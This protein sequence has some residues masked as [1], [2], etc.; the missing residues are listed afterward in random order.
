MQGSDVKSCYMLTTL[1]LGH[2]HLK[3]LST[4]SINGLSLLKTLDI[5][6]IKTG[7]NFSL[8]ADIFNTLTNLTRVFVVTFEMCCLTENHVQCTSDVKSRDRF[9]SCSDVMHNEFLHVLTYLYAATS[10]M[11]NAVSL[12]WH[13]HGQ[14]AVVIRLLNV[15]LDF[16][17]ALISVY[18]FMILGA[19]YFYRGNIEYV[20]MHWKKSLLCRAAG[21]FM[22]VSTSMSNIAT[23]LISVD[24]CICIVFQPFKKR[25]FTL[26]Q[27]LICLAAVYSLSVLPLSLMSMQSTKAI[28]NSVCLMVGSSMQWLF[29]VT[30][31]CC[32]FLVFTFTS[33]ECIAVIITIINSHKITTKSRDK[34]TRVILRLSAVVLTNF[35]PS[36]AITFL[37]IASLAA[38][39]IPAS[40]E[41]NI[42]YFL[43]PINSCLNPVINT[44][45]TQEFLQHATVNAIASK[46]NS[47]VVTF[48]HKGINHFTEFN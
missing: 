4:Q 37:S 10:I 29:S 13:L 36:M 47:F 17:D 41:A 40:I 11:L 48:V 43:F 34:S 9:F 23:L 2:T 22:M 5:A 39:N 12:A 33:A 25:G 32:N 28:E 24:R 31:I 26:S 18:L 7:H 3:G 38:V 21:T 6:N 44:I 20:A 45:T 27:A 42:A 15:K 16:A 30:Y 1:L 14:K 8:H 35:I 19:H 46:F